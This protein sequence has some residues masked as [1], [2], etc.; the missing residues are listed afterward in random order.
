MNE[1]AQLALSG[2]LFVASHIAIATPVIRTPLVNRIGEKVYVAAYS[3]LSLILISWLV[4]SY[5]QIAGRIFLWE[6]GIFSHLVPVLLMPVALFFV[7]CGL[8]TPNLSQYG[9]ERFQNRADLVQGIFRIT[10]HPVQWGILL[11]A[12][13]HLIA[14]GDLA[15]LLFFGALTVLSG[16]GSVAMDFKKR[17]T[18]GDNWEKFSQATSL[19]PFAA[20]VDG[21]QKLVWS[22]FRLLWVAIALVSYL[23]LWWGHSYLAIGHLLIQPFGG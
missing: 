12:F 18:L 8:L 1:Y 10:R 22:E 3:L 6:P 20:I 2:V 16:L 17:K 7:V 13:S 9:G 19:V 14:A 21:R 15:G 5:N 4:S 11:W 23:V